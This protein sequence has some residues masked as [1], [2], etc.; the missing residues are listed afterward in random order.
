MQCSSSILAKTPHREESDKNAPQPGPSLPRSGSLESTHTIYKAN[1][2]EDASDLWYDIGHEQNEEMQKHRGIAQEKWNTASGV[3][4]QAGGDV[5]CASIAL[6]ALDAKPGRARL[7]GPP[8]LSTPSMSPALHT[9]PAPGA[10]PVTCLYEEICGSE[11]ES[12]DGVRMGGISAGLTSAASGVQAHS[13]KG[14]VAKHQLLQLEQ[15]NLNTLSNYQL[16]VQSMHSYYEARGSDE[17]T[18]ERMRRI[19][20]LWQDLAPKNGSGR[21]EEEEAHLVKREADTAAGKYSKYI[22]PSKARGGG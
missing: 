17:T 14:G 18:G 11:E 3:K 8:P 5:L 20:A 2:S 19:E 15:V 12:V 9:N 21:E 6:E 4:G 7:R 10:F 13:S 22:C 1:L 16:F